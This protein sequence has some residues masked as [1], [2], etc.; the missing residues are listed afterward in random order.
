MRAILKHMGPKL[1]APGFRGT[2]Q[3]YRKIDGDFVFVVNFQGSSKG[4]GFYINLGAQ[5]VFVPPEGGAPLNP[6]HLKEYERI[7]RTRAGREWPWEMSE[8]E[9]L[10]LETELGAAQSRFFGRVLTLRAAL[11]SDPPE[12]LLDGFTLGTTRARAALHLARL[13]LALG[14]AAKA[15][16]LARMG[17]KLAGAGAD[18]LRDELN[19][20]IDA[21]LGGPVQP[22]PD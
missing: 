3:N 16:A 14:H 7:F 12:T 22:A 18:I 5:P 21:A 2:G 4:E 6:K 11:A 13:G 10:H 9:R 1:R 20:V 8:S 15:E 17:L 19:T